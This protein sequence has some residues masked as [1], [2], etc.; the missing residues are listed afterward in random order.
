MIRWALSRL[1]GNTCP[2]CDGHF[3]DLDRHWAVD[4]VWFGLV[5]TS[6]R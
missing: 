5:Q 4:H 1:L 3:H 6:T 2:A